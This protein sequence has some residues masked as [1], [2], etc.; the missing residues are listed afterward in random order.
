ATNK[1]VL[2]GSTW[3]F[4]PPMAFDNCSGTNVS[5]TIAS[6]VT[7]GTCPILITRTWI[8]A[9]LCGNTN[10]WSQTVTLLDN[11]PPFV[12]SVCASNAV[13][14]LL[15]TNTCFAFVPDFSSLTNFG[16]FAGN[17]GPVQFSQSPPAGTPAG[18]GVHPIT[19]S[20]FSCGG[21]S[22]GCVL[23]FSV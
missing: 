9:D 4:D 15:N 20:A 18:L 6:T 14:S 16:C 1:T 3:L 19:V 22:N 7:N 5:V 2:C 17:C 10:T 13:A 8:L 21:A 11:T 12:D 23:P